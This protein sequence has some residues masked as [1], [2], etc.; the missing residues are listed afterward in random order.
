LIF[1]VIQFL[2]FSW[3]IFPTQN[4][5]LGEAFM[6]QITNDTLQQPVLIK[7]D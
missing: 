3:L 6:G 2:R 4:E 1:K 7:K 5:R